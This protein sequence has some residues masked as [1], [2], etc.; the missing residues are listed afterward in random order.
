[1][2]IYACLQMCIL[3]HFHGGNRGS[4]PRGDA[5]KSYTYR[6]FPAIYMAVSATCPPGV[7]AAVASRA[8]I[9]AHVST[10]SALATIA[11]MDS[12]PC[13]H[14]AHSTP[15]GTEFLLYG[16][17]HRVQAANV[18]RPWHRVNVFVE[19]PGGCYTC[20]WFG[21]RVA[22]EVWCGYPG[23]RTRTIASASS[24]RVLGA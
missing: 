24:L 8:R 11:R 14:P 6:Y 20:R 18:A 13:L 5:I 19:H 9:G 16:I 3:S 7:L 4:N 23:G 12:P 1:M 21:H 10:V 2:K 22:D 15:Y 17:A